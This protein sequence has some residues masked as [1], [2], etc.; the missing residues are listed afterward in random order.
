MKTTAYEPVLDIHTTETAVEDIK[1]IFS[2][3]LAVRLD[4]RRVS[5]PLA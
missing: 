1:S 5:A 2:K 4:L 3:E